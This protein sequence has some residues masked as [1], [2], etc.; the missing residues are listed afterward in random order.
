MRS[1]VLLLSTICALGVARASTLQAQSLLNDTGSVTPDSYHLDE[2]EAIAS[3]IY[4]SSSC[5]L[6]TPQEVLEVAYDFAINELG[7]ADVNGDGIPD[8]LDPNN[9]KRQ[10]LDCSTMSAQLLSILQHMANSGVLECSQG[11]GVGVIVGNGHATCY[12]PGIGVVDPLGRNGQPFWEF[13]AGSPMFYREYSPEWGEIPDPNYD[14]PV[15]PEM[16]SPEPIFPVT[17][18]GITVDVYPISHK[19]YEQH[20]EEYEEYER[21]RRQLELEEYRDSLIAWIRDEEEAIRGLTEELNKCL[22]Y[23]EP[24][25]SQQEQPNDYSDTPSEAESVTSQNFEEEIS[26]EIEELE[27]HLDDLSEKNRVLND[28]LWDCREK[29]GEITGIILNPPISPQ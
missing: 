2:A 3:G 4:S 17:N 5:Y 12:V 9:Y 29:F 27:K 1:K 16:S 7:Y 24:N 10:R 25:Q 11:E 21:E 19:E 14:G 8:H 23:V 15:D 18:D 13:P 22:A 26:K 28:G 20:R 6:T